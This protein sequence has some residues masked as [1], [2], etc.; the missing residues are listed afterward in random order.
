M[1][2]H[3]VVAFVRRRLPK[4]T[5]VGH[6]GTLDPAAAGVLLVLTGRATR[7]S[8][9]LMATP[10]RYRALVTFGAET[11]T[12]DGEGALLARQPA[13]QL[14]ADHVTAL[15]PA[16]TGTITQIPPAASAIKVGGE[17]LYKRLH[18][19]ETVT[20]PPRQVSITRLELLTWY[21]DHRHPQALI[22]VHCGAGTYIRSLARDL[23][24]SVGTAAYLQFLLRL[25]VGRW[26]TDTAM[27]LGELP[28]VTTAKDATAGGAAKAGKPP[29]AGGV[30][31]DDQAAA[32]FW[33]ARLVAPVQAVDFLPPINLD[34][35]AARAAAHGRPV[36]LRPAAQWPPAVRRA[37]AV[38]LLDP[39][40][41]LVAVARPLWAERSEPPTL[42]WQPRPVLLRPEEVKA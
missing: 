29:A 19:G 3:D 23:G 1:T 5:R 2:S 9:L 8:D 39:A 14:T 21:P 34:G 15:F 16:Y 38:R 28:A 36:A 30:A 10:K 27:T 31:R 26:G 17:P 20:P 24:R 6:A 37:A 12:G 33:S 4:G 7:L 41:Q 32:A 11:S 18:R 35:A 42:A 25:A 13:G 22:D 40:G